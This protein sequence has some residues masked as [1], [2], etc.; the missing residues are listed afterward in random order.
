MIFVTI[1]MGLLCFGRWGYQA[2]RRVVMDVSRQAA[3]AK[4]DAA[5]AGY[6]SPVNLVIA[7]DDPVDVA[8]LGSVVGYC[9]ADL[10]PQ[11]VSG[12]SEQ[13]YHLAAQA[14]R[15]AVFYF[16]TFC[17]SNLRFVGGMGTVAFAHMRRASADSDERLVTARVAHQSSGA[18]YPDDRTLTI[19]AIAR[20]AAGY[21]PYA[22]DRCWAVSRIRIKVGHDDHFRV[23]GGRVDSTDPARFT[24]VYTLNG[25][26]GAVA[27]CLRADDTITFVKTGVGDEV[28]P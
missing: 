2:G 16:P 23:Y 28:D 17:R 13:S 7:S 27:G 24:I 22:K 10:K 6:T 3:L 21:W 12:G 15:P 1:L 20:P 4:R 5:L 11:F 18:G 26:A 25:R 9:K 14:S 8:G 19:E